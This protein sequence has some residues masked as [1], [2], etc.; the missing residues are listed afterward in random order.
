MRYFRSRT[1]LA[2]SIPLCGLLI[3]LT[4]WAARG[5][6]VAL[7]DLPQPIASLPCVS[8]SPFRHPNI[9]PFNY[10]V[11]VTEAQIETDLRILKKRTNCIRTYGLTQGLDAV[12]TVAQRL[13]MRVKLGVWLARDDSPGQAQNRAQIDRGLQLAQQYREVV[14]LLVVGN[15][16]L[17]RRELTQEQL[18]QHLDY[19]KQRSPVPITYADVWE[20][21]Q[22]HAALARHVDVVT[23]HILPYWEDDPVAVAL[24]VAH[25]RATAAQMQREFAPKPVWV[26]ETGWPAAGRQRAGAVPGLVEQNRFVR[27]LLAS[28]P[29]AG[30]DLNFIEAFDQPWKR[31]FE[32]AMGGYWGLFDQFGNARVTLRGAVVEDQF[33]WRGWLGAAFGGLIA[34]LARKA[35]LSFAREVKLDWAEWLTVAQAGAILGGL[36]PLQ[37]LMMAQWD[38]TPRELALSGLLAVVSVLAT[39]SAVL[40]TRQNLRAPAADDSSAKLLS[41]GNGWRR[42]ITLEFFHSTSRIAILFCAATAALVLLLD[43]RYRPFPWWWFLA[44]A[45]A[46]GCLAILQSASNRPSGMPE[47]RLLACILAVCSMAILVQEGWANRQAIGYC[48]IL[49]LLAASLGWRS[50]TK[51]M[52]ASSAAGAHKSVV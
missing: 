45:A 30:L 29:Q 37:W 15:E 47:E 16:V 28:A 32:G 34:L 3:V 23:V 24:A 31:S 18:G 11:S 12:P 40:E 27:E 44:P 25:V 17:L 22:R 7:V 8:Y 19:A 51:T 21:W 52:I 5:R 1:A 42:F 48:A 6:P 9:N 38:R 36:L 35:A 33:W 10:K 26:G 13:G 2:L 50:R 46:W 39:V 14:D 41:A 49:L 4:W 43:A 20:F